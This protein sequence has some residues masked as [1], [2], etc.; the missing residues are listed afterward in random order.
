M[1]LQRLYICITLQDVS[2]TTMST[3]TLYLHHTKGCA[4]NSSTS[5]SLT[6]LHLHLYH[7]KGYN[8]SYIILRDVL[9]IYRMCLQ[10]IYIILKDVPTRLYICIT[11][12]DVSTTTL[13]VPTKGCAYNSSTSTSL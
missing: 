6:A 2:T 3:M 1:C 7:T 8:S 5:T 13:H 4:Y 11:L 10:H 12:Q 9:Y